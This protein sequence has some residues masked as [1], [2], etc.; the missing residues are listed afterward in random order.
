MVLVVRE[1]VRTHDPLIC[2]PPIR[3]PLNTYTPENFYILCIATGAFS[4]TYECGI[5]VNKILT[6]RLLLMHSEAFLLI[7]LVKV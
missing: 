7:L 1:F 3:D 6:L 4:I 2:D 5:P